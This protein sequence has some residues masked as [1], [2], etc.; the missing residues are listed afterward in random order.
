MEAALSNTLGGGEAASSTSGASPPQLLLPSLLREDCEEEL[1]ASSSLFERPSVFVRSLSRHPSAQLA[2]LHWTN[3]VV[4]QQPEPILA[5][6]DYS[7]NLW[8]R[9]GFLRDCG[10]LPSQMVLH[11]EVDVGA[12]EMLPTTVRAQFDAA[13]QQ[14]DRAR[15]RLLRPKSTAPKPTIRSAP[16]SFLSLQGLGEALFGSGEPNP[17]PRKHRRKKSSQFSHGKGEN[18]L[19]IVSVCVCVREREILCGEFWCMQR[20]RSRCDWRW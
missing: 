11:A 19:E 2:L 9:L 6:S 17:A 1:L 15:R 3:M 4:R 20:Q 7:S 13:L 14:R 10:L 18:G 16:A 8:L 5:E 12:G